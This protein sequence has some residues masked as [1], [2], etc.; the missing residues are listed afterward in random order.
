MLDLAMLDW[1]MLDWALLDWAMLFLKRYWIFGS[2]FGFAA[3]M[4]YWNHFLD[5]FKKT[6]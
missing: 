1:T 3:K 5:L 2:H 6:D 4:V